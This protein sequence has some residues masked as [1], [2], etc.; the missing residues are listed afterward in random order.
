M[1]GEQMP[2]KVVLPEG[3]LGSFVRSAERTVERDV[4]RRAVL[5]ILRG[6]SDVEVAMVRAVRLDNGLL[7]EL[8]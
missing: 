2:V 1:C 5:G 4:G 6:G 3:R 7:S 8:N